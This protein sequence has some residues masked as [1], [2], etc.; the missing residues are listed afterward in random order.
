[1]SP[2][3]SY[4][5]KTLLLDIIENHSSGIDRRE[6]LRKSL[7]V[8]GGLMF[9]AISIGGSAKKAMADAPLPA[10]C[11][12]YGDCHSQCYSNCYCA[13]HGNCGRKSW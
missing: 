7:I 3:L 11:G 9:F 6:F 5:A 2:K 8:I 12:C 13:C 10:T 1:M 4:G